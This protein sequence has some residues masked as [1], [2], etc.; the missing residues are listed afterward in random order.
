MKGL[1]MLRYSWQSLVHGG[2]CKSTHSEFHA[3][4][5]QHQQVSSHTVRALFL[6]WRPEGWALKMPPFLAR[7]ERRNIYRVK[8]NF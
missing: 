2:C 1:N 3:M 7:S 4:F 8:L 5:R 6:T